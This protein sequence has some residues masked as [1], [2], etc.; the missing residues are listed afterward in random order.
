MFEFLQ[1]FFLDRLRTPDEYSK[2]PAQALVLFCGRFMETLLYEGV[3][4]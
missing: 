3:A 4:A 2:D 1:G